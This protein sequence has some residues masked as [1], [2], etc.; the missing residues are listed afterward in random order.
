MVVEKYDVTRPTGPH[1]VD[2]ESGNQGADFRGVAREGYV[3][4]R[5]PSCNL[6]NLFYTTASGGQM[7]AIFVA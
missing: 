1:K 5:L 3:L 6:S 4:S 2:A 7:L